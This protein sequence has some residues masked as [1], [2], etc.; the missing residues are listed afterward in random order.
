M[1]GCCLMTD[2]TNLIDKFDH[3]VRLRLNRQTYAYKN[4][5]HPKKK[6]KKERNYF[7]VIYRIYAYHV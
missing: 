5:N 4:T 6:R 2:E 3:Q 7:S 1:F